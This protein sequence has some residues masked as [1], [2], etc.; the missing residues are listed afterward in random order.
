MWNHMELNNGINKKIKN[1]IIILGEQADLKPNF[2]LN[3]TQLILTFELET[4]YK[5]FSSLCPIKDCLGI[6]CFIIKGLVTILA[7]KTNF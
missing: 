2:D 1:K 5:L 4:E 7:K 3:S 6:H